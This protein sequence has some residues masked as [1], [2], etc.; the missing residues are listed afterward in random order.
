MINVTQRNKIAANARKADIEQ[1]YIAGY[2][3]GLKAGYDKACADMLS[4]FK[5]AIGGHTDEK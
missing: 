1:A 4:E 3:E 2:K 5:K